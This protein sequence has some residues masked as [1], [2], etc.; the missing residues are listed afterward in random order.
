MLLIFG[1]ANANG[2]KGDTWVWN[3]K[4]WK[5]LAETGPSPR[6]MGYMAYDKE[7][8]RTVL[9]GG[10]PGWPNDSGDTWEW[11]GNVWKEIK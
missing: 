2:I 4:E 9:F 10:R 6:M 1:A 3:G 11:D 5:L 7:R 8:D